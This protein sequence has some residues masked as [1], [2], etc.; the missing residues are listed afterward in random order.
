MVLI[1][2]YSAIPSWE[3]YKKQGHVAL[4]IALQKI[5][6][7][8]NENKR[9]DLSEFFLGIE[10]EE[11]I[12]IERGDGYLSLH[13]VKSGDSS[14]GQTDKFCFIISVLQYE[15]KRGFFHKS[16]K[17]RLDSNFVKAADDMIKS[18]KVQYNAIKIR[19]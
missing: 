4:F 11:D 16:P 9:D 7:L 18:L 6:D 2:P 12:F 14:F 17:A 3:G 13:Q 10:G 5:G 8:L 15:A 19:H 1:R